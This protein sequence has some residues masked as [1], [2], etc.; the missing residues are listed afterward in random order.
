MSP[1]IDPG[2]PLAFR[3][4]EG[5]G[6]SGLRTGQ[7]GADTITVEARQMRG[8]Q[9]EALVTEGRSGAA[10]RLPSDEGVHLN[11]TDLAPFPL[12]F[13]NAGLQGDLFQ[14]IRQVFHEQD[15][16]S[17]DLRIELVNQYWLAGSFAL[18]TGKGHAE[19]TE[20]RIRVESEA[21]ASAV[22]A[23]VKKALDQSPAI[24]LLRTPIEN[25]FA[26]Y[27][28]GRR[29]PV[30]GIPGSQASDVADPFLGDRAAPL[31]VGEPAPDDLIAKPDRREATYPGA[32]PT[33]TPLRRIRKVHG[34]GRLAAD[35][36]LASIES[37]LELPSAS[38]FLFR[39]ATGTHS[40]APS[41]LALLSAGI[42]CCYMTQLARY[43]DTMKMAVNGVRLVQ[44][45]P[46]AITAGRGRALPVDT[47]LF[48][49]GDAPKQNHLRLLQIAAQTCYLHASAAAQMEPVID[50]FHNGAKI[51]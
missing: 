14:R 11:G 25:T 32:M 12:G 49:D 9:K 28:N 42:A 26:L 35:S 17:P 2:R 39:S 19:P 45:S 13:F 16:T 44:R 36:D 6:L 24:D 27:I 29:R 22:A 5:A 3:C 37:W 47:H 31:P 4:R 38:P 10:W 48:L 51:D 8:H 1:S 7:E 18:G 20:I 21:P 15:Q 46:Y 50:I 34:R 41:G 23:R 30:T 43:I 40:N 33:G